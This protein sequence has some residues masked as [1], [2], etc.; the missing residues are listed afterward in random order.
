MLEIVSGDS[1]KGAMMLA[2]RYNQNAMLSG[3]TSHFG[4]KPTKA[5]LIKLFEGQ[6]VGGNPQDVTAPGWSLDT[7][8]I[9]GEI[10]N[11]AR[12]DMF[13]RLYASVV[14]DQ[15]DV[16]DFFADQRKDLDK[17]LSAA[18]AGQALR[19][20]KSSAP[21]ADCAYAF[22]CHALKE[23]DCPL[24][25]IDML[26]FY[27]TG[28]GI[29]QT[30]ADWGS[31][32]AGQLYKFL[33]L[34]RLVSDKEK[35]F[36]ASL[37]SSLR[38]ENAPLR[39]VVSGRLISVPEDFYDPILIHHIPDGEFLMARLIGELLGKYPLGISDGW[40]ALRI[41]KM[42]SENKLRVVKDKDPSHPYAKILTKTQA[43]D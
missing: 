41:K 38:N 6:P 30:A 23:I 28:D 14:F 26:D 3:P 32:P 35:H 15:K 7:S 5:K 25:V 21:H 37:W 1:A 2:K 8:D 12:R 10:D 13:V 34:Q 24:Y 36:Q 33:P 43:Y 40:Y 22:V 18:A 17:M 9:S 19:V 29:T 4:R 20:W 31:I 42:I 11:P 16:D 39:A 27:E